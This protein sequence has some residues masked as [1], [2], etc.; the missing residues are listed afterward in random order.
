MPRVVPE[1][2]EEA[3]R[4]IIEAGFA[5]L[6][7]KGYCATTMDDIA[8]HIGV[9]KGAIYLYFKNKD[10]LVLEIIKTMD[11]DVQET[12]TGAFSDNVPLEGWT[13]ILDRYLDKDVVDNSLFTEVLAMTARNE[14]IKENL[15]QKIMVWLDMATQNFARQQSNGLVRKDIDPRTLGVAVISVFFGL[16]NLSAVGIDQK[17]IRKRWTEMGKLLFDSLGEEESMSPRPK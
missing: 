16:R 10:D 11:M 15:S 6:A 12:M 2:R 1:Y 5:V 8:A 4:R 13:V 3:R 7:K 9:S 17:E 14:V